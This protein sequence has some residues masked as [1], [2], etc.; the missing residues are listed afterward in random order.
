MLTRIETGGSIATMGPAGL[1]YGAMGS[2]CDTGAGTEFWSKGLFTI[3]NEDHIDVLGDLFKATQTHYINKFSPLSVVDKK[4]VMEHVLLG[5]PTLKIGGYS[6][7]KETGS[8]SATQVEKQR[9][10]AQTLKVAKTLESTQSF[11]EKYGES[12]KS[13]A[14][15]EYKI[16]TNTFMDKKPETFVST[17][18]GAFIVG[19]AR[20]LNTHKGRVLQD[21]FAVSNGGVKWRELLMTNGN[22]TTVHQ[23]VSYANV[24]KMGA[25]THYLGVDTYFDIILMGDITNENTWSVL[26]YYFP[27]GV[28]FDL[29][30]NGAGIAADYFKGDLQYIG[31]WTINTVPQYDS[32][33]QVPM[34]SGSSS[35]WV[36]W[37][38]DLENAYNIQLATDYGA[39]ATS[40]GSSYV[41][42]SIEHSSGLY[43][44]YVKHPDTWGDPLDSEIEGPFPGSN[45][46]LACANGVGIAAYE[47][48]MGILSTLTFNGGRNWDTPVIVTTSGT[49]P[50]V[51]AN[52]D[53][54]FDCY[55]INNGEIWKAHSA[56]GSSWTVEGVV[57]GIT[58]FNS[59]DIF[60]ATEQGVVYPKTD[61][62]LY[63]QLYIQTTGYEISEV[64]AEG[65]IVKATVANTGTTSVTKDWSIEVVGTLPIAGLFPL[66]P[67]FTGKVF[68]GAST[69]GSIELQPGAT[70]VLESQPIKGIGFVDVKVKLGDKTFVE[71]GFLLWDQVILHHPRE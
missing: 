38:P 13:L 43:L 62:D 18:D 16:T 15:N 40:Y 54:S 51:V 23:A 70:V 50:E 21:G 14:N 44:G 48:S 36:S 64:D 33:V 22:D 57:S 28:I 66:P 27:S 67:I 47:A 37:Y 60:D 52:S 35:N 63:A 20:E 2:Y 4:T 42:L 56:D 3:Y 31:C 19:Y 34:F 24:G 10:K 61:G 39:T 25:G 5:D 65:N 26:T 1:G 7:A 69:T 59:A 32:L 45:A 12:T 29:G 6:S 71:D 58:G 17:P 41:L 55:Y 68:K 11:V 9:I 46:D 53:G 49:N 30:R 8:F